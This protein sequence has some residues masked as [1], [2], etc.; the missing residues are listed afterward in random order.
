MSG[1]SCTIPY[2]GIRGLV[3]PKGH[4]KLIRSTSPYFRVASTYSA[5]SS[6]KERCFKYAAA[7]NKIKGRTHGD[8]A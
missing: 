3:N 7:K 6:L 4:P 8:Y 5:T 2:R 1:C